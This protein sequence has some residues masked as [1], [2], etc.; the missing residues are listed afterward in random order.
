MAFLVFVLGF[1][2]L[3]AGVAGGYLSLDL[4]PT[5]P[6]LLYAL[7]GAVSAVGAIIVF[8]LG[9]LIVR[10]GRLTAVLRQQQAVPAAVPASAP[11]ALAEE[12]AAPETA[13]EAEPV[14]H[15]EQAEPFEAEAVEPERIEGEAVEIESPQPGLAGE[16]LQAPPE[17]AETPLAAAE[18]TEDGTAES[19]E[20]VNENRAGRLP[21]L[22]EIERAIETPE[23]P[24][25]LIGRYTSGGANYMIFSDGSIEAETDEGAFK[26]PSMSE[27]KKFLLE[28]N[29]G[30]A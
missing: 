18:E 21:T 6:G 8:V 30:R 5:P 23:S 1:I 29:A 10:V 25:T 19:E 20:P 17:E 11:L 16:A 4:L 15:D 7:A 3:A 9:F 13:P 12:P 26:F 27:F 2:L 24:P 28:R 14:E 22:G